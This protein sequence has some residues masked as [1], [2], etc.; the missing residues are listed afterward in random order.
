MGRHDRALHEDV[1]FP[2]ER[3]D[4]LDSALGG[5]ALDIAA[6]IRQMT[7]GCLMNRMLP[8]VNLDHRGQECAALEV[9]LAE[10]LREHIKD[11]QQPL[12]GSF[13]ASSAFCL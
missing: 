1:P 6:D 12:A 11:C 5:K 13:A 9:R 7:D 4:I 10:P 3:I 8:V 2:C